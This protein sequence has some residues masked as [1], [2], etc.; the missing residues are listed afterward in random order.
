MQ[1]G[2]D[3]CGECGRFFMPKGSWQKMCGAC[4]LKT[5]KGKEW[6]KSKVDM[7]EAQRKAREWAWQNQSDPFK[8]FRGNDFGSR[9]QQPQQPPR[10]SAPMS[11]DGQ[12]L[13][14][15]IMLCHPDKHNNSAMSTEVTQELLKMRKK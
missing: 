3:E 7:E 8:N 5:D 10:Q 4:F 12:L 11:F 6:Q 15:L 9:Y 14:K 2:F 1:E 13:R